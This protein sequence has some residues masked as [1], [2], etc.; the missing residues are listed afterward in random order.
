MITIIKKLGGFLLKVLM[1]IFAGLTLSGLADIYYLAFRFAR[2]FVVGNLK[3][4][5]LAGAITGLVLG[6][7]INLPKLPKDAARRDSSTFALVSLRSLIFALFGGSMLAAFWYY[8]TI[9]YVRLKDAGPMALLFGLFLA[10][11]DLLADTK[12][13]LMKAG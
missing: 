13:S 6:L 11:W 7:L 12:R 5:V 1:G 9:D 4:W 3:Y 10:C 2:N 8:Y